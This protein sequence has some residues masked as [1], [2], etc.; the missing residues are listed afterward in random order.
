MQ[1]AVLQN[2]RREVN[3]SEVSFA[4]LGL[5]EVSVVTLSI[6][7]SRPIAFRNFNTSATSTWWTYQSCEARRRRRRPGGMGPNGAAGALHAIY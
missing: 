7:E 4:L 6:E 5:P 1:L 3:A 2:M